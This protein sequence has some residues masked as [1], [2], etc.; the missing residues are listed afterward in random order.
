MTTAEQHN[1]YL[2]YA[3]IAYAAFHSLMGIFFGVVMMGMMT[4]LPNSGGGNDPPLGFLIIM[5]A[6]ILIFT[7]GWTI[8]SMIAAYALL[9]RKKWAKTAGIVA[10]VFAAT[11]MPV[12]TAVCV[13]TFWFL[14]SENGRQLYDRPANLLPPA[15]PTD[16]ASLNRQVEE[17][18]QFQ[19]TTMSPPDWR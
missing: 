6:M 18:S 8:P 9:K 17:T 10:G 4:T 12:G 7:I 5:A 14:F 3:H 11:Q 15:P 19:P 13:Y 16:W 2:A 1:K